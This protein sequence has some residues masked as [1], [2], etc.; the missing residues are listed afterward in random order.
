MRANVGEILECPAGRQHERDHCAGEVFA[1]RE[2]TGHREDG[3]E[4]HTCLLV[5]DPRQDLPRDRHQPDRCGHAQTRFAASGSSAPH[6]RTAPSAIPRS[7]RTRKMLLAGGR[8][9]RT[10]VRSVRAANRRATGA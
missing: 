2:R 3:D 10:A 6:R 1:E 5:H 7:D 4:I 9:V 8:R